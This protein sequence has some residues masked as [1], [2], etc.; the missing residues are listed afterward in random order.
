[1][2]I[3]ECGSTKII[4]IQANLDNVEIGYRNDIVD[5]QLPDIGI[6]SNDYLYIE[7]CVD[8]GTIQNLSPMIDE[9]FQELIGEELEVDEEEE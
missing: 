2:S 9:T 8:C 3:C 7:V 4:S 1:M 6:G 5:D